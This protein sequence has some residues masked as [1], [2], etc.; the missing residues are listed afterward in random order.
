VTKMY[1]LLIKDF[2]PSSP[3]HRVYPVIRTKFYRN[4]NSST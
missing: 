1:V 3:F 4:G 2:S